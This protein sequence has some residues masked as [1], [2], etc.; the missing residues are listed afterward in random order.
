MLN[1]IYDGRVAVCRLCKN[2][3][4]ETIKLRDGSFV[5]KKCIDESKIKLIELKEGRDRLEKGLNFWGWI[6]FVGIST[7]VIL[8]LCLWFLSFV[9]T[10]AAIIIGYFIFLICDP[11]SK[12]QKQKSLE[13]INQEKD[14]VKAKFIPIFDIFWDYP[15]DW[16]WRRT[17]IRERDGR[18]CKMCSRKW[19]RSSVPF[20]VH[21]IIPLYKPESSHK[22]E[23][24]TFLCEI[25]HSKIDDGKHSL[26]KEIRNKRLERNK[27][28]GYRKKING[29]RE[30][31]SI[32]W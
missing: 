12:L 29:G 5:C 3:C 9:Y 15:P 21:H 31:L 11:R 6:E 28:Y 4:D 2:G 25:C 24:L 23:N 22:F 30:A 17:Q 32:Y 27:K 26:V 13:V 8:A 18:K 7:M 16:A 20:H 19:L 14:V 1:S 10:I